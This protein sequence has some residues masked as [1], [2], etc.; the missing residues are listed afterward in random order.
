MGR[1]FHKTTTTSAV[2]HPS[3]FL[4]SHFI[5]SFLQHPSFYLL[6]AVSSPLFSVCRVFVLEEDS[7]SVSRGIVFFFFSLL[8]SFILLLHVFLAGKGSSPCMQQGAC[9]VWSRGTV[10]YDVPAPSPE[11]S[12]LYNP[13]SLSSYFLS[14]SLTTLSTACIFLIWLLNLCH[15]HPN[16]HS[17]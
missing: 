6:S 17:S 2:H 11:G 10:Q 9:S 4:A 12:S 14:P 8:K 15:I 7:D 5:S 16:S 1:Y 13:L 3:P